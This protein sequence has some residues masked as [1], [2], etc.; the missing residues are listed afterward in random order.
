MIGESCKMGSGHLFKE[1][2][3]GQCL[4]GRVLKNIRGIHGHHVEYAEE[5]EGCNSEDLSDRGDSDLSQKRFSSKGRLM[6]P[7]PEQ[8]RKRNL[9]TGLLIAVAVVVAILITV[10]VKRGDKQ[11]S[12]T[13]SQKAVPTTVAGNAASQVASAN[14]TAGNG[15]GPA[16]GG[17]A[18][19]TSG[20]GNAQNTAKTNNTPAPASAGNARNMTSRN[21]Q[22]MTVQDI[23]EGTGATAANGDQ[24]TVN[25]V[26]TLTNGTIFDSSIARNQPFTFALGAGQVIKGW[27]LGVAGMKVGGERKLVIPP[28]LGY[29]SQG[30]PGGPIPPNATLIF[31]VDLL[32]VTQ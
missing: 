1:E 5:I 26:G 18:K 7:S 31:T 20:T 32:G 12:N 14:S 10:G 8:I 30:T 2:P 6:G 3:V 15:A 28:S 19:N 29:G 16:N 13:N 22:G 23:K 27:D 21:I 17:N 24:V 9:I 4:W 25:Y 11:V